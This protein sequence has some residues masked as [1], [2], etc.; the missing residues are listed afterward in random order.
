MG[1]WWEEEINCRPY[2]Y[3]QDDNDDG[4]FFLFFS[5]FLSSGIFSPLFSCLIGSF[6]GQGRG[7]VRF[8]HIH[9]HPTPRQP[10]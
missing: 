4:T 5:L 8:L 9:P 10:Y 1:G 6:L 2:E 3:E 7:G